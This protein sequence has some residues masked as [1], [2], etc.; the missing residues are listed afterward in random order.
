[1]LGL[2]RAL[3]FLY[4][5]FFVKWKLRIIIFRTATKMQKAQLR[6]NPPA[7]MNEIE[8]A[9]YLGCSTRHIRN[10]VARRVLPFIKLGRRRLFRL[11]AILKTL[12]ETRNPIPGRT[13]KHKENDTTRLY[14]ST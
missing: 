7:I 3:I 11:G 12:A 5:S 14:I 9:E 10:L 1:M 8:L 4:T 6:R 13:L 2:Q